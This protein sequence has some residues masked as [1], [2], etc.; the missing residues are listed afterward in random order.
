MYGAHVT[1]GAKATCLAQFTLHIL[2]HDS[3]HSYHN[4]ASP[5]GL[6]LSACPL[7]PV[8]DSVGTI[9]R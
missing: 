1:L 4:H 3:Q 2:N 6:S 8:V 5:S 9:Y 7:R